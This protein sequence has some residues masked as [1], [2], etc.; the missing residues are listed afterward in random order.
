MRLNLK[1]SIVKSPSVDPPLILCERITLLSVDKQ[2][3]LGILV[4]KNLPSPIMKMRIESLVFSRYI[5][6]LSVWRPAISK[7]S[8]IISRIGQ[9]VWLVACRSMT[10][11]LSVRQDLGGF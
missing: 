3:Y 10:M 7:V 11:C 2:R 5:Y 1:K 9:Y 6:A 4:F 8:R